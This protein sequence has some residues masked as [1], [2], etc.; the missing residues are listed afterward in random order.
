MSEVATTQTKHEC[1]VGGRTCE[2]LPFQASMSKCYPSGHVNFAEKWRCRQPT[3]NTVSR[4]LAFRSYHCGNDIFC[5][6]GPITIVSYY[7]AK[8]DEP[9]GTSL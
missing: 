8:F 3:T 9:G 1:E 5:P 7:Q 4:R 6:D 2:R